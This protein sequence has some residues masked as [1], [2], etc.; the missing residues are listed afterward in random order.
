MME[1]MPSLEDLIGL[2]ENSIP[3]ADPLQQL[4]DSVVVAGRISDLADELIGH[5]VEQAR[6]SGATWEEIGECM[7]VSKQAAQ[8]RSTMKGP[9]RRGGFFLTRLAE[10]ARDVVQRAVAHA[11]EVGSSHVG[12]EHLVLGLLADSQSVACRA[13]AGVG[14]P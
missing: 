12:T 7:G 4:T 14:G 6:S 3:D 5:F 10:E 2:V 1:N 11:R 13:I 8:K 9:R